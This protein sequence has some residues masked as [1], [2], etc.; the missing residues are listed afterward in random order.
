MTYS[1]VEFGGQTI[2]DLTNDTATEDKVLS[3]Y[4][5]HK[6]NGQQVLGTAQGAVQSDWNETDTTS[7]AYILNK[8]DVA[9]ING[10]ESGVIGH[11]TTYDT[12]FI[13]WKDSAGNIVNFSVDPGDVKL[14]INQYDATEDDWTIVGSLKLNNVYSTDNKPT[15]TELK[16]STRKYLSSAGTTTI[17]LTSAKTYLVV[18][19]KLN[20]GTANNSGLYI[21]QCHTTSSVRTVVSS[22]VATV[23][24]S[25]TTLTVTTSSTNV[26][27]ECIRL[28]P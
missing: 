24:I 4:T 20:N 9:K 17:T 16:D 28:T 18:I 19:T 2:I 13:N 5:F 12:N 27:I 11:E 23:S 8:P 25:G 3:G 15:V 1:K 14:A 26:D 10:I 7:D 21:V 6:A 22:A